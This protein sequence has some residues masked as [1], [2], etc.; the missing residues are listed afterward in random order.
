MQVTKRSR[1]LTRLNNVLF[2]AL[3][4]G[5]VGLLAWVSTRYNYQAD[6]T[7]NARQHWAN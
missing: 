7:A 1:R 6:W 4:L 2:V 5:V 3:L